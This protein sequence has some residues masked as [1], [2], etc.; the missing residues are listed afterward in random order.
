LRTTTLR[1]TGR[2]SVESF[3]IDKAKLGTRYVCFKCGCK[4]YDLKRPT[5][6]CPDCQ[7]DQREAPARD[8][9]SLLGSK[10][11]V[12][13]Y[14][15]DEEAGEEIAESGE[16]D[17]EGGLLGGLDDDDDEELDVGEDEEGGEEESGGGGDEEE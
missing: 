7:A 8:I 13:R 12:R 10:G 5:P 9:R 2:L 1:A 3:M 4:F 15:D 17:E 6:S 16:E 11:A 14:T